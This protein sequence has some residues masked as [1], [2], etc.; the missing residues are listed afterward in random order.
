MIKIEVNNIIRILPMLNYGTTL[1][2]LCHQEL[3]WIRV[4][5]IVKYVEYYIYGKV[6]LQ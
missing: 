5:P 2:Q 6:Y 1:Q 3:P 4:E